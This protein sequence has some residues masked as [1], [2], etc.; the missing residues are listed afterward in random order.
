[1]AA[2]AGLALANRYGGWAAEP[3][4]SGSGGHVSVYQRVSP[5]G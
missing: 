1:M 4:S 3:F 5:G 2:Q